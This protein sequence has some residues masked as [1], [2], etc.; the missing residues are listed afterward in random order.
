MKCLGKEAGGPEACR[1]WA[2][3]MQAREPQQVPLCT[4]DALFTEVDATHFNTN[5]TGHWGSGV[6][7]QS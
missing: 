7:L 6:T 2:L 1:S 3:F 5:V 4:K